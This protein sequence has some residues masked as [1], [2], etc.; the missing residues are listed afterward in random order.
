MTSSIPAAKKAGQTNTV[1]SGPRSGG[2]KST[3]ADSDDESGR[4]P[5]RHKAGKSPVK[6][7][8]VSV[9]VGTKLLRPKAT[10][11]LA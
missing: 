4:R 11:A 5:L 10:N 9:P 7:T 6:A 3:G 2:G 8:G 1:A